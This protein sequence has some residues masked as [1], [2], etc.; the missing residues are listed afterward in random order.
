MGK[1]PKESPRE[2]RC[3]FHLVLAS[4]AR[5]ARNGFSNKT[6]G[7]TLSLVTMLGITENANLEVGAGNGGEKNGARDT[8]VTLW[9]WENRYTKEKWVESGV[10]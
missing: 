6:K 10:T 3:G 1:K 5:E 2:D 9:G 7:L 8:L 4:R